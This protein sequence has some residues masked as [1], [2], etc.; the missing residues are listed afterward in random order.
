MRRPFVVCGESPL[1]YRLIE[2]LTAQYDGDV[3]AIVKPGVNRWVQRMHELNN[4]EIVTAEMLDRH[5]FVAAHLRQAEALALVDQDDAANVEAALL[6]QEINPGLRIVIRMFKQSLGERISELLN[7][8]VVLSAA[9]IAAPAFVAAALDEAATPPLS[10]GGRTVVGILR[11]RTRDDDVL[12]GLAVMGPRGSVPEVLPANAD[13]RADL[14][15]A[16]AKPAPPPRAPRASDSSL[17]LA[18]VFG[19]RMRAVVAVF[20][21]LYAI[22]TGAFALAQHTSWTDAAFS[23]LITALTGN[24]AAPVSGLAQIAVVMLAVLSVGFVPALTAT[25]VDGLVKLRLQRDAGGLYDPI[26]NHIVVVGLGDVGTRVVRAL[27]DQGVNVVAV[28]RDPEARGVPVAR[29]LKIP[30]I[31]GDAARSETLER[32]S[33]KTCRALIIASTDDVTNL[34]TALLGQAARADLR[35]VLR[36]F[37]GEFADRVRRAF[38]INISRSVSYLAAPAF[39]AAMIGRQVLATIPVRR[40]VMLLAEVP[41]G[42]GSLLEHKTVAAVNRPHESRLLAIRTADQVLW[43][44]SDGR[45]LRSTDKLIVVTTRAGLSHLLAD[46][47][48]GSG[49]D[50]TTPY[51][52]LQPWEIPHTRSGSAETGR[53]VPEGPATNP[54]FGPADAGS[55]RPA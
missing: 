25:I 15:L 17:F 45:P 34:E 16:R 21:I 53:P 18:L 44:P 20:L 11:E 47:T 32:A 28:E 49:P 52:L 33:V 51:R 42:E 31:I 55:T 46:T 12:A 9:A 30:V 26:S 22:G 54:P 23:A 41:I 4:V 6:A 50:P 43:R 35:V 7:D 36:L 8:G 1:A 24:T 39:A 48:A 3:I 27:Y 2:E 13:E 5:A 40:R 14:V 29:E 10:I 19:R 37:D 38:N